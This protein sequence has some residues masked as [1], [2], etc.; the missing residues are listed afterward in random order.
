[1]ERA[2]VFDAVAAR[3]TDG[4][5][6]SE[7]PR[8]ATREELLRVHSAGTRRCDCAHQRPRG[9]ARSRHVHFARVSRNCGACR[10]RRGAGGRSCDRPQGPAFALVRP[11]GPSCRTRPRDG[12]LSVQQRRGRSGTRGR[13]AA[14]RGSPSSTSTSTTATGRSGSSTTI[15]ASFTY[16]LTSIP[17]YPGTG[18]ANEVGTGDGRRLHVQR[19][20]RNG[21]DGCGLRTRSTAKLSFQ[22]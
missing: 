7:A 14:S 4:E 15:R 17:F 8:P 16:R 1:M 9:D 21:R 13:R 11:P 20:A 3:W 22:C 6:L 19:S 5:G 10:G 18:A 2:H 12:I